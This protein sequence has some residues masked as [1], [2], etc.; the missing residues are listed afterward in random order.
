MMSLCSKKMKYLIFLVLLGFYKPTDLPLV[1]LKF[2]RRFNMKMFLLSHIMKVLALA[3]SHS[4]GFS[5]LFH[6][7]IVAELQ[8]RTSQQYTLNVSF[9]STF[10]SGISWIH[11]LITHT[12]SER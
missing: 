9:D 4:H 11:S 7:S 6:G 10:N 8:L 5:Y 2:A 3:N 12:F 1:Q